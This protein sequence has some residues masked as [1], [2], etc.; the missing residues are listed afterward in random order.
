MEKVQDALLDLQLEGKIKIQKIYT[1]DEDGRKVTTIRIQPILN[2]EEE[3][4]AFLKKAKACG[5]SVTE[6]PKETTEG[7]DICGKD[8][9][10]DTL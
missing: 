7:E 9:E 10:K 1:D 4:E 5:Y 3:V 8:T 2:S 6:I